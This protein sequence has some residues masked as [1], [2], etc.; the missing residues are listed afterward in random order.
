M[1]VH[2]FKDALAAEELECF[3]LFARTSCEFV[4]LFEFRPYLFLH[5]R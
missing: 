2:L 5:R 4:D 1:T 3:F